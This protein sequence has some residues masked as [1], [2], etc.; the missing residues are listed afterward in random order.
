MSKEL[1]KVVT[2]TS[3]NILIEVYG[4]L[5]KP[6]VK[7]VGKAI[8]TILGL[9]NTLLMPIALKNEKSK[10]TIQNN[11]NR[12]RNKLEKIPE[13]NIQ[14]VVP[15]IGV[16]VLEKL[17][18][19][20]DETLVELY[21]ELLTNA[22]NKETCEST[23]PSFV[24]IINNLSPKE[25]KILKLIDN[26]VKGIIDINVKVEGKS[27]PQDQVSEF[28]FNDKLY[29]NNFSAYLSNLVGLGLIEI[30]FS[31]SLSDI[32]RYEAM[33]E[34]IKST[35]SKL[36]S[37]LDEELILKNLRQGNLHFNRGIV[38]TTNFGKLFLIACTNDTN[39]ITSLYNILK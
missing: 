5:L 38:Q 2:E 10:I 25:A 29:D 7:E 18:Y 26:D 36:P 37:Q 11:L 35:Y 28:I 8:G 22:S 3:K 9:G 14:S 39:K 21:T 31:K 17:M 32:S 15:E 30:T 34:E 16:P 4:D 6:G 23:H 27:K 13:E 33:E 12:F 1:A 20:S 24:N 19:V